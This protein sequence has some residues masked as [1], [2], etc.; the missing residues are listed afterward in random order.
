MYND[1]AFGIEWPQVDCEI[2]LS[3]KDRKHPAFKRD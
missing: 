1:P 3:E 2:N